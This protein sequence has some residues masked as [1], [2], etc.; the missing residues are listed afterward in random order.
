VRLTALGLR[1][2]SIGGSGGPGLDPGILR[3]PCSPKFTGFS[4]SA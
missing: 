2:I 1:E 4:L 3:F